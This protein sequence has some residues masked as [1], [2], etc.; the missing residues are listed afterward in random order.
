MDLDHV[1]YTR[2]IPS[3][4]T[5]IEEKEKKKGTKRD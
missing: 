4:W 3:S 5:Q 1:C 2:T